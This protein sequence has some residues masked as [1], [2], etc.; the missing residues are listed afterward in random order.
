M[1][2]L[3]SLVATTFSISDVVK[4]SAISSDNNEKTH[5]F[6]SR[7][8]KS[9]VSSPSHSIEKNNCALIR[10]HFGVLRIIAG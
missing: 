10:L 5:F 9:S 4:T 7:K 3:L 1:S 8:L 6:P 2:V